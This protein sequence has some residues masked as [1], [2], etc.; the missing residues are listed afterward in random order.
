VEASTV[1]GEANDDVGALWW[2]FSFLLVFFCFFCSLWLRSGDESKAGIAGFLLF[3][4]LSLCF[5]FF[6]FPPFCFF[7]PYLAYKARE[8]PFFMCFVRHERLCFFE[9]K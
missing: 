2:S 3:P 9:K 5:R 8:W 1:E 4:F 7:L 6:L